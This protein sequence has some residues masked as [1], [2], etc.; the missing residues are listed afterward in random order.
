M[1]VYKAGYLLDYYAGSIKKTEGDLRTLTELR[2]GF[3][4]KAMKAVMEDSPLSE[5]IISEYKQKR[6][7]LRSVE[8]KERQREFAVA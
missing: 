8:E 6:D 5:K 7:Q 3:W 1:R 4:N 2:L